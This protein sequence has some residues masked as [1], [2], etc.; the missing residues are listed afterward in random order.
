MQVVTGIF[1]GINMGGG[2]MREHA[3]PEDINHREVTN[4]V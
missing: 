1:E 2:G 4:L 3:Y